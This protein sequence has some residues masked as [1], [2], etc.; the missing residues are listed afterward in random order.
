MALQGGGEPRAGRGGSLAGGRRLERGRSGA[1]VAR[2]HGDEAEAEAKRAV[3]PGAHANMS[4]YMFLAQPKS[5]ATSSGRRSLSSI[6]V[7]M[8]TPLS[9]TL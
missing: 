2:G 3:Q 8:M 4:S 1:G 9:S 6:W 5:S 7:W